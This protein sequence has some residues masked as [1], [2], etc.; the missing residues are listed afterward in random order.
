[1]AGDYWIGVVFVLIGV[2]ACLV[3]TLQPSVRPPASPTGAATLSDP[4]PRNP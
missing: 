1:M 2:A 4:T 3:V